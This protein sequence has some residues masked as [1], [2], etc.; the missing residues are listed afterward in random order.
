MLRSARFSGPGV[1]QRAPTL[2]AQHFS[3]GS[4]RLCNGIQFSYT[5]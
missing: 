3:G 5:P 1:A 4:L 2:A